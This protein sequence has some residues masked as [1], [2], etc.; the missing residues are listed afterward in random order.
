MSAQIVPS[1][2]VGND[3]NPQWDKRLLVDVAIGTQE[4]MILDAYGL[5]AH[6]YQAILED[7]GF[8]RALAILKKELQ[9]DGMSFKLKAQ[10]QAEA[11]LEEHWMLVHDRDIPPETR[12]KAIADTVR[13]A[14]FDNNANMG[15]MGGGGFTINIDLSNA[16]QSVTIEGEKA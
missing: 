5:T 1:N 9:K 16:R 14:G 6:A 8:Q 3:A 15:G 7:L 11:M 12:R 4:D 10:L 13:W 2:P